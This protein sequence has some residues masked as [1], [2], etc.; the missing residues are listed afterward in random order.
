MDTEKRLLDI[1]DEALTLGGRAAGFDLETPLMGALPELD[2]MAVI[3]LINLMEER[4]GFVVGE[5]EVD[6]STFETVGSL[7]AY[8]TDKLR[9]GH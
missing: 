7:L 9:Q 3:G 6:A 1:V 4:F 5:D 2:S 8:V